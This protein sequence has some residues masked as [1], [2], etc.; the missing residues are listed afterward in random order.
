MKALVLLSGGIDSTTCL[1]LAIKKYGAENVTA[2]GVSYGQKHIKE[3]NAA[4]AIAAHGGVTLIHLDL[5]A[6]FRYSDSSLLQ[7]S[8][9]ALPAGE[10]SA[11]SKDGT[12]PSTFV[13]FRNGLFLS[14]AAS[15]ALSLDCAAIYYGA[16]SDDAGNIYPDCSAAFNT[17]MNAAVYEGSGRKVSIEAPFI[18]LTKADV[19]KIGLELNAPYHLTW[20]CYEGKEKPCGICGTCIDRDRAFKANGVMTIDN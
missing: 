1:C 16:H 2:L 13:P 5:S 14:A 9:A 7:S 3:I 11:Q 8:G 10:Y 19:V 18:G 17:A 6:M 15:I 12:P 4:E 20:S